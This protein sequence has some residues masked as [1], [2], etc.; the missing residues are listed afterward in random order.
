MEFVV[1]EFDRPGSGGLA[2]DLAQ[3][4]RSVVVSA[5]RRRWVEAFVER[6]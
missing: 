5:Q 2:E 1:K 4:G 3:P 6:A